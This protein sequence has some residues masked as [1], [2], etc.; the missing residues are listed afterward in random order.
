MHLK[1]VRQ[2]F[3]QGFDL[4]FNVGFVY[5]IVFKLELEFKTFDFNFAFPFMLENRLIRFTMFRRSQVLI[6]C[7]PFGSSLMVS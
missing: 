5:L 7:C 4:R 2:L 3:A 1:F 6:C